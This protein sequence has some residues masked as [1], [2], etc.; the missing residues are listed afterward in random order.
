MKIIPTYPYQAQIETSE[1]L[2]IALI[3]EDESLWDGIQLLRFDPITAT[4]GVFSSTN[5]L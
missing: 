2:L 1:L 3:P 4:T 5:I